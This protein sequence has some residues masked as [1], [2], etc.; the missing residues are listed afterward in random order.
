MRGTINALD[1]KLAKS[2]IHTFDSLIS[3]SQVSTTHVNDNVVLYAILQSSWVLRK[4]MRTND[5]LQDFISENEVGR[6][7]YVKLQLSTRTASTISIGEM[8]SA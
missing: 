7:F 3:H 5:N 1:L 6:Y 8:C 2:V 4:R